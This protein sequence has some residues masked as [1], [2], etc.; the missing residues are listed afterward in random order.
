MKSATRLLVILAMLLL[1]LVLA[2]PAFAIQGG[3][4]NGQGSCY[5]RTISVLSQG[6]A[7]PGQIQKGGGFTASEWNQLWKDF[8]SS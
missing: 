8:C 7:T 5:G 4:S 3:E 1:L 2:V 6:G